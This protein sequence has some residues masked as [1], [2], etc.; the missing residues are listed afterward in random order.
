MWINF[1]IPFK[2]YLFTNI[3]FILYFILFY[4]EHAKKNEGGVEGREFEEDEE[5][6]KWRKM[7]ALNE[8]N[9][10]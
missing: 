8:Y 4:S 2:W 3:A 6:G 1:M 5:K 7:D 10:N 9:L